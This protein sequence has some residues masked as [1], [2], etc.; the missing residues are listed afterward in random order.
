MKIHHIGVIASLL[1]SGFSLA[2]APDI[3]SLWG[4]AR[5]TIILKSDGTV[6][7][8][9]SG[10]FGKLGNNTTT[11][12]SLVPVEVHGAA[13]ID[14]L[15]SVTA[16]MGGETHNMALKSDG[17]LWSWG[18]N[19][20]GE[21]GDGTTND[22]ALPVQVGLN[23]VPPLMNVTKLGGRTYFSLAVKSDGTI[24]GWGMTGS[25]QMG[26]GTAG[27]NV[28]TPVIVSNSQP[29]QAVNNRSE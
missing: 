9:G 19:F 20:V 14:Y 12:K 23:S 17:T 5:G 22:A 25:G 28:L 1:A 27:A 4:G 26:N 21:L 8:W 13:S 6:W 18:Y 7:T 3:V 24:W 29:G 2:A 11:G 15:H 10:G 16:I